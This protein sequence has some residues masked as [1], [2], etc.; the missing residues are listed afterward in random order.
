[1]KMKAIICDKCRKAIPLGLYSIHIEGYKPGETRGILVS[2]LI[3]YR[4]CSSECFEKWLGIKR[5][6]KKG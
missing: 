3:S 1:M 6:K 4:F 2:P 5:P